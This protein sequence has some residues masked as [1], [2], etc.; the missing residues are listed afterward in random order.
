MSSLRVNA[1]TLASTTSQARRSMQ[2]RK[3]NKSVS[4]SNCL[5]QGPPLAPREHPQPLCKNFSAFFMNNYC[6][7]LHSQN[8]I[9]HPP[10]AY[11][12]SHVLL[13][14]FSFGDNSPSGKGALYYYFFYYQ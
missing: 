12:L 14:T 4:T 11:E 2:L 8:L 5:E 1:W 7:S 3:F 9:R 10:E 6:F 13:C